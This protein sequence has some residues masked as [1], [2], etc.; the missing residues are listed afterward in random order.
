[1]VT[2]I[3]IG[4]CINGAVIFTEIMEVKS[5]NDE[6]YHIVEFEKYCKDCKFKDCKSTVEPCDTCLSEPTN[7]GTTKPVK[8][9]KKKKGD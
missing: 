4:K 5:M 9:E 7:Y 3:A 6:F 1:M 2:V 8:F